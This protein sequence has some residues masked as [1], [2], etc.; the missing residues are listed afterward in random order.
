MVIIRAYTTIE[1]SKKLI[2]ILPIESADM[3]YYIWKDDGHLMSPVP[4]VLDDTEEKEDGMFEYIPCW[5]LAALISILPNEIKHDGIVNNLWITSEDVSYYSKEYDSYL[6]C[7]EGC[8]VD[9]CYEM[10]I[11]LKE[12]GFELWIQ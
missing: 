12:K 2:E 10:I 5:S 1:Q 4:F 9:A 3:S 8:T 7:E 6:Y 11:K